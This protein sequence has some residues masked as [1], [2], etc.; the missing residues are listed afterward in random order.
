MAMKLCGL[1][2]AAAAVMP[3]LAKAGTAEAPDHLHLKVEIVIAPTQPGT[4][5]DVMGIY[6]FELL[7]CVAAKSAGLGGTSLLGLA[8]K[9]VLLLIPSAQANHRERF[10]GP[11][12]REVMQRVPLDQA[13]RVPLGNIPVATGLNYCRVR[14]TL[15]RLPSTQMPVPLPALENSVFMARPGGLAPLAMGYAHPFD[16]SLTKPWKPSTT[17]AKLT[18][19]LDP[20]LAR[21]VLADTALDIGVLNRR[22]L[23]VIA[24]GARLELQTEAVP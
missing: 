2:L 11:G 10:D 8:K 19:T 3:S 12:A 6:A 21:P 7:P 23:T 16:M 15:A 14:L 5:G 20:T 9:S 1:V 4:P 18:I 24:E 13:R 22:A 17:S